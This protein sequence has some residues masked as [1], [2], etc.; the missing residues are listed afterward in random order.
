[1]S[2]VSV[3]H[4]HTGVGSSTGTQAISAWPHPPNKSDPLSPSSYQLG[5]GIQLG[6]LLVIIS[7][8][9]TLINCN[10]N[11]GLLES[12]VYPALCAVEHTN[13]VKPCYSVYVCVYTV[14][15]VLQNT[16]GSTCVADFTRE[17]LRFSRLVEMVCRN[18]N[19]PASWWDNRAT[20][21]E[22]RVTER[23]DPS[24]HYPVWSEGVYLTARGISPGPSIWNWKWPLAFL[25]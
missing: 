12:N 1:M 2:Q 6:R 10:N 5:I 9:V 21:W 25:P 17:E 3:A 19:R 16:A 18:S 22:H 8:W 14:N 24:C 7:L 4:I 13:I 11:Y 23:T 15:T 20:I